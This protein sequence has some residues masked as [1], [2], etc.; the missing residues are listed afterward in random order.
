M[1]KLLKN[2]SF[3]R[4]L[5]IVVLL[6]VIF[7]RPTFNTNSAKRETTN[8][9][10]WFVVDSTNSMVVKDVDNG[11]TRRY[12]KVQ[13]DVEEIVKAVPGA[14]YSLIIQDYASFTAAPLSTDANSIVASKSYIVPK[15]SVYAQP[16]TL[17]D[18][19]SYAS[20]AIVKSMV[21]YKDRVNVMVFMSDGENISGSN[22]T[23]QPELK[24]L[25]KGAA[26]LGYGST[27]GGKVNEVY[28]TYSIEEKG[29]INE[30]ECEYFYSKYEKIGLSKD[31]DSCIISKIDETSL[32]ELASSLSGEYYHREN[33]SV[34]AEIAEGFKRIASATVDEESETSAKGQ[35]YWIFAI[36]LLVLLLWESEEFIVNLLLEK[37][38]KNA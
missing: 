30:D 3:W 19:L 36:I 2:A 29:L 22:Y 27:S 16:T 8:L 35:I 21:K 38:N 26:V 28:S 13:S 10:V 25:L 34:P 32:K 33:G 12:E 31:S 11:N 1:K 4:R 18:L 6:A 37:E 20:N 7:I 24:G 17:S 5:F 14:R 23:Q 15:S 9:N